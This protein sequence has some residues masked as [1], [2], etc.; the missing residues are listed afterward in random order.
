MF[1]RRRQRAVTHM[2]LIAGTP[3]LSSSDVVTTP[4]EDWCDQRRIRPDEIGAW[5]W[6]AAECA[7]RTPAAS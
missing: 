2:A 3:L 1:G 7:A 5:D 4:F 6:Y